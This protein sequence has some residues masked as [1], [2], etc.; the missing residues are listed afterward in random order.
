MESEKR[1]PGWFSKGDLGNPNVLKTVRAP[2]RDAPGEKVGR[3]LGKTIWAG[4]ALSSPAT[5][6]F[7]DFD[8]G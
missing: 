1:E 5:R 2:V 4:Q 7:Y 3:Y 8:R 6:I